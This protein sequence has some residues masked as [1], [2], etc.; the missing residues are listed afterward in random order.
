M[1]NERGRRARQWIWWLPVR[2]EGWCE[3]VGER[4]TSDCDCADDWLCCWR[5]LWVTA[6]ACWWGVR[7]LLLWCRRQGHIF[8]LWCVA[9]AL[10]KRRERNSRLYFFNI[11]LSLKHHL[12]TSHESPHVELVPAMLITQ[13]TLH[14]VLSRHNSS[15][16][17]RSKSWRRCEPWHPTWSH[18]S[19]TEDGNLF[20]VCSTCSFW[21]CVEPPRVFLMSCLRLDAGARLVSGRIL[22]GLWFSFDNT[23]YN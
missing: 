6:L 18:P 20:S 15:S 11:K 19:V 17:S 14:M 23:Q 10:G 1:R 9:K 22:F 3:G 16:I 5:D 8:Y 4:M 13:S 21:S 7:G 2:R 12:L